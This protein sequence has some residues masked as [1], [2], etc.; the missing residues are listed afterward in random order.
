MKKVLFVSLFFAVISASAQTQAKLDEL[1]AAYQKQYKFNGTALVAYRGQVL[2]NK[3]YGWQDATQKTP[4]D[5]ESVYQ[6]G[7]LTKQF[8]AAVVLRLQEQKKLNVQDKLGKYFPGY[9]N[10]DK[11][12]LE[13]L[14][15][16]TSGIYNYTDDG[17]F[18]NAEATKPATP[19][20]MLAL[21]RDKPLAFEPGS[22][23][24]Y[25]NSG[26]S[27]LGYVIEKVTGQSYEKTVR[28]MILQPLRMGS[29]GFDFVALK[30]PRKAVGYMVLNETAQVPAAVVD[31]SVSFAAGALYATTGDLYRWHKGLLDN[32]V[33]G[34]ASQQKSY[35]PFK[36][37]Y[38][39]G[40]A[41]DTLHG[42]RVVMHSG[43][44]F[45]F[46]SFIFRV[47]EDDLCV[48]LL[49][50]VPNPHLYKIG[51]DLMAVLY[52]KP[53]EL[54]AERREISV[55]AATLAQYVGEYEL[56]PAFKITV[57]AVGNQLKA[58]ATN[59]PSFDMFAEKPDFFFLKAVDAQVEFVKGLDGKVEK[60][61]L[62][63]NGRSLP[64]K[65][66]K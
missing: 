9:P 60:L 33:I 40:W 21:F 14:L 28:Q 53:Y 35:T 55:D 1:L 56:S 11:I 43:G 45:G 39:Y 25:S 19:D 5:A 15:T 61:I 20:K 54:P 17:V 12:T 57:T 26:Y 49:N 31:S 50:N 63:Q 47:P 66:V 32:K 18:M 10:G 51:Q 3:G 2:L 65:K 22:R 52:D 8:T 41:V 36:E 30:N 34:K 58:Q 62:H 4:A 6:I 59:Q 24:S 46:S 37:K 27:L 48:V 13:H 29:S 44:I 23:Y 16:H 7:S 42:K 38:G 64:G